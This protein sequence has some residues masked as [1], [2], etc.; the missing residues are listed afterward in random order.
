[1]NKDQALLDWV[2]QYPLARG[3]LLFDFLKEREGSCAVIPIPGER[4]I[5]KYVGGKKVEKRYDFMI[6]VMFRLS[7][8]TDEK[9]TANRFSL[10]KWQ[11]W[12]EKMETDH[13]Y[14]DFGPKCSDFEL[15]NLSNMPQLAQAFEDGMA[16]YQFPARLTYVEER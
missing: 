15:E 10:R 5:A 11:D 14:P 3:T 12:L 8:T 13:R 4:I 2:R 9:N 7:D 6:Q 16:K 1:M